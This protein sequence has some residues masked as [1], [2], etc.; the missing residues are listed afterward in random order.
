MVTS[1]PFHLSILLWKTCSLARSLL[2]WLDIHCR[3]YL[4]EYADLQ[5]SPG[6]HIV[7]GL[8]GWRKE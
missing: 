6:V 2:I 8:H 3:L 7:Y 4:S 5:L 1:L